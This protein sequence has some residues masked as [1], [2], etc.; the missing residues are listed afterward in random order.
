MFL[1]QNRA[2]WACFRYYLGVQTNQYGR[3]QL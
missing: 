3:K 1:A 2:F